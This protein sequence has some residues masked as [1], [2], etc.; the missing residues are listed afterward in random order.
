MFNHTKP[1]MI[2]SFFFFLFIYFLLSFKIWGM[3]WP[4]CGI[5]EWCWI[6]NKIHELCW[7]GSTSYYQR[8]EAKIV[9][10]FIL[11]Y[12][13]LSCSF[14]INIKRDEKL[15]RC[16]DLFI[17]AS[18]WQLMMVTSPVCLSWFRTFFSSFFKWIL[19]KIIICSNSRLIFSR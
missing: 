12:L 14:F 17:L 13:K 19:A 7:W 6:K 18:T 11:H 4:S 3:L 10:V 16:I 5:Q 2:R 15:P 9:V 8:W 1:T